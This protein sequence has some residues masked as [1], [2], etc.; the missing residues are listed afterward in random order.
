MKKYHIEV[1]G[2]SFE[3]FYGNFEVNPVNAS[4]IMI[5]KEIVF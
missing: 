1:L 3:D 2:F 4:E 5:L